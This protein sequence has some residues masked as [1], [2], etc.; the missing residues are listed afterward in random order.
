MS[1]T[2]AIL[3]LLFIYQNKLQIQANK[4]KKTNMGQGQ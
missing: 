2:Q 1:E 3:L 4:M